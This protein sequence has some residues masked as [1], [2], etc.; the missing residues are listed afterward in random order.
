MIYNTNKGRAVHTEEE[1][2]YIIPLN[3]SAVS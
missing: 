3:L 2:P 1:N